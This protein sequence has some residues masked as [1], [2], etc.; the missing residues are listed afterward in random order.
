MRASVGDEEGNLQYSLGAVF[1]ASIP[2]SP[3]SKFELGEEDDL[4]EDMVPE[5][6]AFSTTVSPAHGDIKPSLIVPQ[7]EHQQG[8]IFSPS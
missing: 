3:G 5:N 7:A 8:V 6:T 1:H 2:S 4:E